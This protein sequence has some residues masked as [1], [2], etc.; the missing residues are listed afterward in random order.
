MQVDNFSD[1]LFAA[2]D[3]K[4][5]QVVVGLDPAY[6]LLPP[7]LREKHE[8]LDYRDELDRGAGAYRDFLFNLLPRVAEHAVAVKPQ[9]AYF[10]ALG[11]AGYELYVQVVDAALQLGLLVIAD[12]KRGDIGS[13]AEAYARAHF[14][15]A[16]ADALTVNPW[17][18]TDGLVPFLERTRGGK[19]IFVLVKTSNPSSKEIQDLQVARGN[20][21]YMK[22]AEL[23]A[24]WGE[25]CVG[26]LG[27]SAVGAVAGGT[28]S[29]QLAEIRQALPHTPLLVPGYGAQG[30]GPEEV[31]GAFDAEGLGAVVN[32][33]RGILYA[34]RNHDTDWLDAATEEA[35]AMKRALW[36]ASGRG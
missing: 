9:L 18:G 11:A 17:F 6:D 34:Y 21:L 28:H 3:D 13:T 15:V 33:S 29:E 5:S 23:T 35:I 20:P 31:A 2:V 25:R 7:I 26:E 16:G 36:S 19:G 12:A 24:E 22:V 8:A 4:R 30:A 32:S 27:Y 1:R 10:E 14:E